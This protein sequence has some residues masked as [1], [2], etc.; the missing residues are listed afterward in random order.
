M[1]TACESCEFMHAANKTQMCRTK[2]QQQQQLQQQ[3]LQGVAAVTDT[4]KLGLSYVSS[5]E[6][7]YTALIC[8]ET[9]NHKQ[10]NKQTYTPT[11]PRK[12]QLLQTQPADLAH[13]T[14]HSCGLMHAATRLLAVEHPD[15]QNQP[16]A[17]PP[18]PPAAATL[19]EGVAGRGGSCKTLSHSGIVIRVVVHCSYL[20]RLHRPACCQPRQA[21]LPGLQHLST[22]CQRCL[23]RYQPL[24]QSCADLLLYIC[25]HITCCGT[26][27]LLLLLG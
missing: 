2:Q 26:P 23:L 9:T 4:M 27:L 15:G 10:T 22:A 3:L 21:L 7:S 24:Q 5:S 6:W 17:A 20:L 13:N 1:M 16:A 11:Q 12:E 18:P 25:R 14:L 19:Q 8:S